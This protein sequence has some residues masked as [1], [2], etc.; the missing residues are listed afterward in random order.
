MATSR[1]GLGGFSRSP[2]GDFTGKTEAAPVVEAF[3]RLGL[4]G[5]SRM[6]YGDFTGKTEAVAVARRKGKRFMRQMGRGMS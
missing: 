3:T 4:S 6:P 2:Y 5:F 1:L